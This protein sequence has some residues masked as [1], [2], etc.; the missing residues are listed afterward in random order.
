MQQLHG[1]RRL[2]AIPPRRCPGSRSHTLFL[3][4][5]G[6][7]EIS[8]S[9][10]KC[11]CV[12][13]LNYFSLGTTWSQTVHLSTLL[14]GIL[15][16]SSTPWT[17]TTIT[18]ST[19]PT[20]TNTARFICPVNKLNHNH[21]PWHGNR[22]ALLSILLLSIPSTKPVCKLPSVT[23]QIHLNYLSQLRELRQTPCCHCPWYHFIKLVALQD[24]AQTTLT[25]P[26]LWVL[27]QFII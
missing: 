26:L 7:T 15:S 19:N 2:V 18:T 27:K 3:S 5:T 20:F 14:T 22:Q 13:H 16:S 10:L 11:C 17:S 8:V 25:T 12:I 23:I 1:L 21:P 9:F 24:E 6:Q 4:I